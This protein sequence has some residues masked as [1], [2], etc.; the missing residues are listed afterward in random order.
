M[1]MPSR[2]PEPPMS[3]L[4]QHSHGQVVCRWDLTGSGRGV[5]QNQAKNAPFRPSE[6]TTVGI[7]FR[8][9]L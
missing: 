2:L 6:V 8:G 1:S 7:S 3:H 9:M 4:S 5:T